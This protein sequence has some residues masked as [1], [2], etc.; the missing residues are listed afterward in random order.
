MENYKEKIII[1]DDEI[2]EEFSDVIEE[3]LAD[4]TYKIK[5]YAVQI[6]RE[7]LNAGTDRTDHAQILYII[8]Q[9][10][11]IKNSKNIDK[12]D[13]VC[14]A[15]NKKIIHEIKRRTQTED[16]KYKNLESYE[17]HCNT[18]EELQDE[19]ERQYHI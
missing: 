3:L 5:K 1:T 15:S 2:K 10:E 11:S 6:I 13:P 16:S 4:G 8:G 18:L 12:P 7:I 19:Y 14:N 17:E 9:V